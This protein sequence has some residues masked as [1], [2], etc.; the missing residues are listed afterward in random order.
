VAGGHF[1]YRVPTGE[2]AAD[3]TIRSAA[4]MNLLWRLFGDASL[5]VLVIHGLM[6]RV[7]LVEWYHFSVEY[8]EDLRNVNRCVRHHGEEPG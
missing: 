8:F 7:I 6:A 3:A 4:L 1:F 5:C 2:L